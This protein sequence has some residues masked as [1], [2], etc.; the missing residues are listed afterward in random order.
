MDFDTTGATLY[1]IDNDASQLGTLDL[2]TAAFTPIAPIT[3]TTGHTWTGLAIDPTDGT[4]YASST[5]G[6]TSTLYTVDLSTGSATPLG[7]VL[8]SPLLIDIAVGPNGVMY[9]HDIGTDSIYRIDKTTGAATLL[10]PTGYPANF[11][12][13]MDFDNTDGTL[14]IFLYMGGG[15][16]FLVQ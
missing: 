7:P 11:A 6:V 2:T 16:N 4:A 8:G 9:G 15:A 3:P 12:Q 13:G 10:G 5:D 14:Y 1:A